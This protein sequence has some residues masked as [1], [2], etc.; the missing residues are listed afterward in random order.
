MGMAASQA[1]LLTITARLADNELQSQTI[2][3]A[4]MRL[5]TQS[6]QA[7]ENYINA[8]NDATLKFGSYDAEGNALSQD[9]TF[10]ALTA[11]SSYNT[12][13][14]LTN[15]SGQLLVSENEA[16]MYEAS[17]GNLNAYLKAHGLE[18]T[19]TYFDKVGSIENSK[20]PEPF[21]NVSSDELKDYYEAY[22]SYETSIELERYKNS[23]STF[24]SAKSK[25]AKGSED[26]LSRYLLHS[27]GIEKVDSEYQL[28]TLNKSNS[29]TD[30][31]NKFTSAFTNSSNT[32]SYNN[33]KTQEFISN[34]DDYKNFITKTVT[35][36]TDASGNTALKY[37]EDADVTYVETTDATGAV[38]GRTYSINDSFTI[39]TD[40]N[41]IVTTGA[42]KDTTEA[43]TSSTTTMNVT[44]GSTG[45]SFDDYLKTVTYTYSYLD[46]DTNTTVTEDFKFDVKKDADGNS[47]YSDY[48][49]TTDKE[50]AVNILNEAVDTIINNMI[51]T[52]NYEAFA[53]WLLST[54][55]N[56][57]KNT[58]G[59]D[60][61]TAI[62]K[63]GNKTLAE[64]T[65]D[66][67][68]SKT[69]FIGNIFSA[70]DGPITI[71]GTSY[72]SSYAYIEQALAD[73]SSDITAEDL[74]DIDKVLKF[75]QDKGLTLASG[76]ET[77][78][79]S[80]IV[81]EMIDEYGEP[82]YAWVD[83][84][85][86]SNTGNADAKA[87]WYTNLFNRMQKGYK[88][89]ENGLA[90]SKEWIEYAL[91]SGIVSME[92]VDKSYNWT[93]LDYKT[94][95]KITEETDNDAVTKAEAEYNRAMND[96]EAKDNIYDIQLKNIDTEHT[97][98]QTEYESIKN[99]ITKNI[100]RTFK[101]NQSA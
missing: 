39:V 54:D 74:T 33:T 86:T 30:N 15:A 87:Q 60:T 98:L 80:F 84:N 65:S 16:A 11:Y 40:A 38:T 48:S 41:G 25:L 83:E 79:K 68:T 1:R 51:D 20:Y 22:N 37:S 95:T 47:V 10:N 56:T 31:Y 46:S 59:I 18:Y 67:Q 75:V 88:T 26:A 27:S 76:Y 69:S 19:T 62:E 45:V 96:I 61:T 57:L 50:K 36:T 4:K 49:L 29:I 97:S 73:S 100:E 89:L 3:N 17:N 23:Y 101:F 32:Y 5:A 34:I 99:V 28:K 44:G 24:N 70:D 13:Y 81:E 6:S 90:S 14:G 9:L 55:A 91:E 63:V 7:S 53:N 43:D 58:Y 21:N 78:I 52:A 94:C 85:D 8:L 72:D 12:Q 64:I 82:K 71:D 66:Y 35:T 77:V 2:N 92:Q 93:G 42:T